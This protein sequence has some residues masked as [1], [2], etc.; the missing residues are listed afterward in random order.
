[1]KNARVIITGGTDGIGF[2]TAEEL[3][4]RGANVTLVGRNEQKCIDTV[5]IIKN[6]TGNPNISHELA[7]LSLLRDVRE[8]AERLLADPT[9]IDIL[10]NNAGGYY[11]KRQ[12]TDEGL[13]QTFALN[14]MAYFVLTNLLLERVHEAGQGRIINVASGV[15]KM[16]KLNFSDP[17]G[18]VSY[19]GWPAYCQ[20]KLMNVMFTN[21]LARR[22]EG[23]ATTANSLHPGFVA[24]KFGHNN[25][26]FV[27][28]MMRM[29]QAV[30]A[31]SPQAGAKTSVHLATDP[32]LAATS[33]L[34]FEKSRETA[35]SQD[36]LNVEAQERLWKL[37]EEV[38]AS[39]A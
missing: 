4:V 15:H 35:S 27:G 25:T 10:V 18:R 31:I 7:D 28:L 1:M 19:K 8:L 34:Y 16:G 2:V 39:I 5:A 12:Q 21:A 6:T 9:P 38:A 24:S 36:S 29:S 14:H 20:S 3:A 37:S 13:E 23:T 32:E 17:Q 30:M 22:L 26:G 11:Q 33:G